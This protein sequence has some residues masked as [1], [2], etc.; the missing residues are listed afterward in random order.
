MEWYF[1]VV[2]DNYANFSGR[3]RR[4]EFW[5]FALFNFIIGSVIL[6][7]LDNLLGLTYGGSDV[8]GSY[9]AYAEQGILSSIYSLVVLIPS[10]AVAVRRLHDTGKSGWFLLLLLIPCVGWAIL[11]YFYIVEGDRETNQYGPDPKMEEH[12]HPF[13]NVP[14]PPTPNPNP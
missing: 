2:R 13:G 11:L 14:P 9:A 10:L 8:Y 3:A 5:M 7:L 6:R 12:N 1:N 4:K